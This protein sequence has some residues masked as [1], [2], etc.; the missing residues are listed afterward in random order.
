MKK[1]YYMKKKEKKSPVVQLWRKLTM[2]QALVV[3]IQ[4][5]VLEAVWYVMIG[6]ELQIILIKLKLQRMLLQNLQKYENTRHSEWQRGRRSECEQQLCHVLVFL[7]LHPPV[8]KG[9]E[10]QLS[11]PCEVKG[12]WYHQHQT[13]AGPQLHC[14]LLVVKSVQR[15]QS[16]EY[17]RPPGSTGKNNSCFG[18]EAFLFSALVWVPPLPVY[19]SP[20]P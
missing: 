17:L 2:F 1:R 16:V 19:C 20:D 12:Q 15:Q 3:W 5:E 6:Q 10:G 7:G 8:Q 11:W 13:Q 18:D 9:P 14:S 4:Q